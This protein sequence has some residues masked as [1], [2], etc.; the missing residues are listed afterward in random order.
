VTVLAPAGAPDPE[1][2]TVWHAGFRLVFDW[3]SYW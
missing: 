1:L 3:R 2:R